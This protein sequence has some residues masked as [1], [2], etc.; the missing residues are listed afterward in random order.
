M[1]RSDED[2]KSEAITGEMRCDAMVQIHQFLCD[3]APTTTFNKETGVSVCASL[4][5]LR[6]SFGSL[7]ANKAVITRTDDTGERMQLKRT[8]KKNGEK[9]FLN[10]NMTLLFEACSACAK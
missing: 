5:T 8:T 3:R 2:T 7:S 9:A 4:S 10:I 1:V 6:H